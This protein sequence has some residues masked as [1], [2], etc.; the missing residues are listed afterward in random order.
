MST[1]RRNQTANTMP[2]NGRKK[3]VNVPPLFLACVGRNSREGNLSSIRAATAIN[4]SI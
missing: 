1:N 3:P 2:T 4:V